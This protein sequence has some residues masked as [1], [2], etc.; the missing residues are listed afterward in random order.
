MDFKRKTAAEILALSPEEQ[1]KYMSEQKTH[2]D[3]VRKQELDKAIKE[4]LE[5]MLKAQGKSEKE[6]SDLMDEFRAFQEGLKSNHDSE[7][8]DLKKLFEEKA[9]EI[10]SVYK[11]QHGSVEIYKAPSLITT[12][13]GSVPTA[14]PNSVGTQIAP[15]SDINLREMGI[16][17]LVRNGKTNLPAYVYTEVTPKEGDFEVVNEGAVKPLI[18]IQWVT[19]STTPKK[20]AAVTKLTEESITDY[21]GLEDIVKTYLYKKHNLKKSK[22]V[23]FGTGTGDE[24]KGATKY[25]RTFVAGSMAAKVV[26]PNVMDVINAVVTDVYTTHN[27]EDEN[28]YMPNVVLL[29]PVDF[30]LEFV[31]AKDYQGNPLYPTASLFNQVV[32]GNTTIIPE[33]SIPSGKIFVADLSKYNVLDYVGYSVRIGWENDDM[34]RNQ[35]M[36]IAESR[37][38]QFVKKA[39]ELA[40]VYDDIAT[41]KTAITK[42]AA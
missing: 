15:L 21:A 16:L 36:L 5:P 42:P 34:R 40:F 11:N 20:I 8:I 7:Q 2:D 28:S 26:N 29:N 39:D 24:P 23:L 31:S 9:E 12:G 10:R 14:L 19:R 27:Y 3:N 17:N 25:A 32:I 41:I 1:E 18:D 6:I 4:A 35:F 33:Q 30:F 22:L 37:F 13:N 38:F